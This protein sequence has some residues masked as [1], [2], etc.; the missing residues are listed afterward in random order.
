MIKEIKGDA[1]QML[2]DK[3]VNYLIHCANCQVKMG[4]GIALQIKKKIPQ[5]YEADVEFDKRFHR[6]RLD[7][8]NKLGL[9]TFGK[10][11][12]NHGVINIYGQYEPQQ[13]GRAVNY[14][15]L[16][17]GFDSVA[18]LVFGYPTETI[19]LPKLL[20]CDRAGGDWRIVRSML[21]VYFGD[22][23]NEVYIVEW[24]KN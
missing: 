2:L 9:T 17:K 13:T 11:G 6:D 18:K 4:S 1:V 7:G 10:I 16:A 3:Q 14:E 12:S 23:P 5:A 20:G 22:I 8:I 24:D 15:A 19:C 21:D